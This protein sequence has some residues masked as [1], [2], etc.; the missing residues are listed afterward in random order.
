[1]AASLKNKLE[2]PKRLRVI[3]DNQA[4]RY[5]EHPL[6][7]VLRNDYAMGYVMRFWSQ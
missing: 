5:R 2:E 7:S 4:D 6:T 3:V 1:M